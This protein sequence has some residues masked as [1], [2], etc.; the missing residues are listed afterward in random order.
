MENIHEEVQSSIEKLEDKSPE[1]IL[2]T[3]QQSVSRILRESREPRII[4]ICDES[5]NSAEDIRN[6]VLNLTIKP[7]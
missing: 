7:V 1:N 5:N 4:V 6:N 2:I 3:V